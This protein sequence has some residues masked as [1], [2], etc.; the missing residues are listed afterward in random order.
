MGLFDGPLWW[1]PLGRAPEIEAEAL[2]A[3][4][5]QAS[6]PLLLDMR[7]RQEFEGGHVPGARRYTVTEL[8]SALEADTLGDEG[9]RCVALCLS[10]HR[11]LPA[12]RLL[13]RHGRADAVHLRDGMRAWWK[14]GLTTDKG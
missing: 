12:V 11:S 5:E 10:A 2:A 4:L 13:R 9:R 1:L 6:P 7:S 3:E 8:K 14:A